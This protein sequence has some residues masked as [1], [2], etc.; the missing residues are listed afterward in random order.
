[1][2]DY[3]SDSSIGFGVE[4]Y[5]REVWIVRSDMLTVDAFN[6]YPT[7]VAAVLARLPTLI[8]VVIVS[9]VTC[10]SLFVE[11]WADEMVIGMSKLF[12]YLV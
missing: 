9:S 11:R 5:V 2:R 4:C 6:H 10:L 12:V 8:W 1:M 7:I 3:K